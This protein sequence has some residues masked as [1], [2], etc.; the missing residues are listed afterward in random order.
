[1][2]SALRTL[3]QED[4]YKFETSLVYIDLSI[5]A[6][7]PPHTHMHTPHVTFTQVHTYTPYTHT[8]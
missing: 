6:P 7:P 2:S 3:R 5:F 8:P 1:M 4:C